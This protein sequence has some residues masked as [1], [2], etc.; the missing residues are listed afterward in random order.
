M[1]SRSVP[2][3]SGD[4]TCVRVVRKPPNGSLK[5]LVDQLLQLHEAGPSP[6]PS[7]KASSSSVI[8]GEWSGIVTAQ[9]SCRSGRGG[10]FKYKATLSF[11]TPPASM[12][13]PINKPDRQPVHAGAQ[14][15]NR[16]LAR[17][18][19]PAIWHLPNKSVSVC[20]GDKRRVQNAAHLRI[21]WLVASSH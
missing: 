11:G 14:L 7:V 16:W 1:M 5:V 10:P 9:P 20:E 2:S 15:I 21:K 12:Q 19:F 4:G 18:E 13:P 6:Q 8:T 3:R 17:G